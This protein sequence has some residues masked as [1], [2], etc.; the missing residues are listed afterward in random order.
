MKRRVLF[1]AEAVTLAH[2]TR[3][4]ALSR[5]LDPAAY[6]VCH[7]WDPRYNELIGEPPSPYV[8]IRTIPRARFAAALARGT[9]IYQGP[10]LRRYVADDLALIERFRPD[11]VVGDFRLSLDVSARLAGVRYLTVTNGYWSPFAQVLPPVPDITLTRLVGVRLAQR[12]FDHGQHAVSR[13][14]GRAYRELRRH[15]GLP[16]G[17]ADVRYAYTRADTT[18]YADLPE[19]VPVVDL[20]PEH[21][22]VGPVTWSPDLP[23]PQWWDELPEDRPV[24]YVTLGS[25]GLAPLLARVLS[26]LADLPVTVVAA[27]AGRPAPA[28]VPANARVAAMLPAARMLPRAVLAIGNGGSPSAYQA[29]AAGVPVLGICDNLD[30][31]LN[32]SL[33]ER[34]GAGWLLR[35]G[36]ASVTAIRD[37]V[38]RALSDEAARVRAGELA[39]AI[40]KHDTPARF[41]A[42]LA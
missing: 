24:V 39:T 16:P 26:A 33:V 23:C 35:G 12:L 22:F 11:V 7:A 30:Q 8:P 36:R 19:L 29:L 10:D 4:L 9:P 1:V 2:V 5:T 21:H 25:S 42:A 20:P 27:T 37:A 14:H 31:Y 3:A 17:P 15:H 38:R 13:W 28:R 18:L 34:A 6:E 41:R 40:D 32:M